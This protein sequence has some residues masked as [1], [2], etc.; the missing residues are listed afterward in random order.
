VLR[1]AHN[2]LLAHGKAVQVIRAEA[3]RPVRV[4]MAHTGSMAFPETETPEN[5][6]AA[7]AFMFGMHAKNFW[8]TSWWMDPIYFGSY[9]ADGLELFKE[10]MPE[11]NPRDMD[12]IHQPLDFFG[13]NI[14]TGSSVR[15][16]DSPEVV[17]PAA[18]HARTTMTWPVHP[19]AMYWGPRL[20]YER[21][22]S[23]ILITENGMANTDWV[24]MD[25][26]VHDPQ[27]ID[28]LRRYLLEY[29]RAGADGVPLLG[30]FHWSIL[31]NFEWGEG[32]NQRFGIIY[33][34]Y[35][36]QQR[37]MKDSAL[38]YRK[39]IDTNGAA[40]DQFNE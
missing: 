20:L 29:R 25:G 4:G 22:Q 9:P 33:V 30:Y 31:D 37:T 7:R 35:E 27:R 2:T 15:A 19:K 12:I 26:K 16:G 10:D 6:E 5:V 11:I 21:Y 28:Y 34:D 40:L 3:R 14:Y 38:W 39:V 1:A 24:S 23:P 18:G 36:T 32:Y 13:L 17:T 8:T